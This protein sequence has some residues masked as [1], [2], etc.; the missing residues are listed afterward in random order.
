MGCDGPDQYHGQ[1]CLSILSIN[2][3]NIQSLI[4]NDFLI[5]FM[6]IVTSEILI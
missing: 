4:N 1:Y 3:Y 6:K 5:Y 2:A